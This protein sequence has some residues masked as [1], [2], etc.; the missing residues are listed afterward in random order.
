L[1]RTEEAS[2]VLR[3]NLERHPRHCDSLFALATIECDRAN[4]AEA[5][6]LAAAA[7]ALNPA[8]REAAALL[9]QLRG[10]RERLPAR[11]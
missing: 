11:P 1:R 7:T 2:A 9:A 4:I 8:D 6:R 3:T 10:L 5:E